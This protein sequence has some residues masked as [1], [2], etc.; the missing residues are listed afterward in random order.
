VLR[1]VHAVDLVAGAGQEA[2][3]EAATAERW[4]RDL[5]QR[6]LKRKGRIK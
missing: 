5:G 2:L 6:V 4:L 3:L 1:A